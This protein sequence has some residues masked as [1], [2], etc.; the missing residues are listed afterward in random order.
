MFSVCSVGSS[1]QIFLDFMQF[2]GKFNKIVSWC[3]LRVDASRKILDLPLVCVSVHGGGGGP[4][5]LCPYGPRGYPLVV[6]PGGLYLYQGGT[7]PP[8]VLTPGR[9]YLYQGGTLLVVTSGG[10]YQYQGGTDWA[11]PLVVIPGG[12]AC[13]AAGGTPLAVTLEDFLV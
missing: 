7:P 8:L 5:S 13:Y 4:T 9:W 12:S 2:L 11:I 1:N 6:T 10:L 3:P